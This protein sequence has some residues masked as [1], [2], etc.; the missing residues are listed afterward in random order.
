MVNLSLGG[1]DT[2]EVDPL[3]AAVAA[4]TERH[5]MLFVVAAGNSGNERSVESPA[6]ADAAL[7]VGA[8]TKS[9]ELAE[10]SSRGPRAADSAI[11][12]D[13]TAPGQEIVAARAKDA[14]YGEGSY[15]SMDGTSMATRTSPGPPR[16]W[17]GST[18]AGARARSRRH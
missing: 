9:G 8:V 2:P 13:L 14:P 11:K 1:T 6:S 15:V 7:A 12:P 4:L 17:P 10:F 3:E 16:S 5:D 18:R